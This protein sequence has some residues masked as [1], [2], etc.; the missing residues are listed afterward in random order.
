[1]TGIFGIETLGQV[2]LANAGVALAWPLARRLWTGQVGV[3]SSRQALRLSQLTLLLLLGAVLAAPV[4]GASA[5]SPFLGR[6]RARPWA[7][8][9]SAPTFRKVAPSPP[10]TL[11]WASRPASAAPA[12]GIFLALGALWLL[13]M[14]AAAARLVPQGRRLARIRRESLRLRRYGRVE[15][16]AHDGIATPFAFWRPGRAYVFLP[17]ASLSGEGWRLAVRHE[18]QH[19]RQRDTAW[20]HL[21]WMLEIT[22]GWN[23]AMRAWLR[24]IAGLQ[25]FACDE[26]LV[27]SRVEPRAYARCLIEAAQLGLGA[28]RP[29]A[30]TA[31]MAAGTSGPLLKRRIDTSRAHA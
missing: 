11:A 9:W 2:L 12:R 17:T 19:H 1:M 4:I 31:G 28:R 20:A 15:I 14:A 13:A 30:G 24:G 25:E 5:P 27:S 6:W 3:L 22:F 8:V 18:L 7:E 29:L 10:P 21:D 26:A 16:R 23:P